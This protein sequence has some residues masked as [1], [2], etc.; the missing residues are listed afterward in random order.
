MRHSEA[1]P[2]RDKQSASDCRTQHPTKIFGWH[3]KY[4]LNPAWDARHWP[5]GDGDDP[6]GGVRAAPGLLLQEHLDPVQSAL[7]VAAAE[8]PQTEE[9]AVRKVGKTMLLYYMS[10]AFSKCDIEVHCQ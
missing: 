5:S 6:A 9:V 7:Q 3:K 1:I 8:S 10:K 4:F 2:G